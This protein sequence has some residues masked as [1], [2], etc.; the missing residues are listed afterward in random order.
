MA[1]LNPHYDGTKYI[2][3]D[4]KIPTALDVSLLR[5]NDISNIPSSKTTGLP[6]FPDRRSFPATFVGI[7]GTTT[8]DPCMVNTFP[9]VVSEEV[10]QRLA[11]LKP[12][13][14]SVASGVAL[15]TRETSE[16][17][18]EIVAHGYD[19]E[20]QTISHDIATSPGGIWFSDYG[21]GGRLYVLRC[22][23]HQDYFCWTKCDSNGKDS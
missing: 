20:C 14:L 7:N 22:V 17:G 3:S 8:I 10:Q 1:H 12:R 5:M 6:W 11:G 2:P 21:F 19:V 18:V 9:D 4:V 23:R 15:F 16:S 13:R